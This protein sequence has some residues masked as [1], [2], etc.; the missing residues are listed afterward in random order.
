MAANSFSHSSN[1]TAHIATSRV[2]SFE[3]LNS[4]CAELVDVNEDISSSDVGWLSDDEM[5]RDGEL[6][7]DNPFCLMLL[8]IL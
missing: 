8:P 4:D 3:P 6:L 5:L 1:T 2:R 7:L